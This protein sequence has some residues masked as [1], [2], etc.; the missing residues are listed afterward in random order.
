[1]QSC[2]RCMHVAC[3]RSMPSGCIMAAGSG[4]TH[5]RARRMTHTD[6]HITTVCAG[7][8]RRQAVLRLLLQTHR[9]LLLAQWGMPF[10]GKRQVA[11]T[12]INVCSMH[13]RSHTRTPT[14]PPCHY[15][16]LP[17]FPPV[18]LV[19]CCLHPQ[20][21]TLHRAAVAQQ[22]VPAPAACS[23]SWLVG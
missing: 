1:M 11:P 18:Q 12:H 10:T 15:R 21:M 5:A 9:G 16:C 23:Q 20:V 14:N 7:R 3:C 19:C 17:C 8:Q 6:V 13:E 2:L 4:T 22:G